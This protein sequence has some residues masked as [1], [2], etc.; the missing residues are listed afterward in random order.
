MEKLEKKVQK[1]TSG[2]T[3]VTLAA[4]LT[5]GN[6]CAFNTH[7]KKENLWFTAATAG[8]AVDIGITKYGID[9]G[10]KYE[11]NFIYGEDP[12]IEKMILIKSA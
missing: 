11:S 8:A 12:N 1:R 4:A 3:A 6:G 9:N 7:A 2:L 5:F 10:W